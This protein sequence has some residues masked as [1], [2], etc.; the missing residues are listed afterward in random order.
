MSYF[1]TAVDRPLRGPCS[2]TSTNK[3]R[4]SCFA[5]PATRS[6]AVTVNWQDT[7]TTGRDTNKFN[8]NTFQK[9]LYIIY[10]WISYQFLEDAFRNHKQHM[11]S[12]TLQL[13]EKKK[14]VDDVSNYVEKRYTLTQIKNLHECYM[15]PTWVSCQQRKANVVF[16]E[17]SRLFRT[18][19][20]SRRK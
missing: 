1:Q 17:F 6:L 19:R 7:R 12:L 4:W 8:W 10:F 20:L 5:R 3:S 13:Q 16:S 11:E 14:L 18:A 2:V 15:Q 9:K